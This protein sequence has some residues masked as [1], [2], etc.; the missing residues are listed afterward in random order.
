MTPLTNNALPKRRMALFP[1]K[2]H[3]SAPDRS[4]LFLIDQLTEMGGAERMMFELANRLKKLGY[5]VS[6]ITFRDNPSPEAYTYGAEVI[7]LPIRSCLSWQAIG[8]AR[9]IRQIIREKNIAI[10]QTYFES[11]DLFGAVV[12]WLSGVRKICSSRRDMGL[13]RTRKHMLLYKL[14]AP[15][16]SRVFAVSK[17]VAGWHQQRDAIVPQKMEVIYNGVYLATYNH[18]IDR[19]QVRKAFGIPL[20]VPVVTTIANINPWK[21]LD[22]FLETAAIVHNQYPEIAFV[23]AGDKTDLEH[24]QMLQDRVQELGLS[25]NVFFLGRVSDVP[26]LLMSSDIFT[27]LSRTEGFPNVVIEAMAARVP[28]VATD[29]GGTSEVVT[30]GVTGYLVPCED[31]L[32]AAATVLSLLSFPPRGDRLTNTARALVEQQFSI[33]TMVQRHIEVYDALLSA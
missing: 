3:A 23:I 13:L 9:K 29:V 16:Y 8:V 21:G 31:H 7:V 14:C 4:I 25:S 15:L 19:D 1:G 2:V 28:V 18:R 30:D 10:A 33:E 24:Y 32:T 6:I 12:C 26:S 5:T 17:R 20:D 27:L 22:V 11:S